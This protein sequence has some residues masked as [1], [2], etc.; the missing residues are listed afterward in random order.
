VT[1]CLSSDTLAALAR[2]ELPEPEAAGAEAHIVGC[3]RC[4][5]ALASLPM[6]EDLVERLRDLE[7]ARHDMQ[8]YLAHLPDLEERVTSTLFG[9]GHGAADAAEDGKEQGSP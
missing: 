3:R 6:S 4:A 8:P 7:D 9:S 5:R 2:G 1:G